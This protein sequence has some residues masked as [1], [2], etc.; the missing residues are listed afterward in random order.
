MTNLESKFVIFPPWTSIFHLPDDRIISL[1]FFILESKGEASSSF[2][3]GL[4]LCMDSIIIPER[5]D[6]KLSDMLSD[7]F[8]SVSV[9]LGKD[10]FVIG[11]VIC[12]ANEDLLTVL[13]VL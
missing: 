6:T 12:C 2:I 1:L 10:G 9:K 5:T 4:P 13:L 7:P 8:D 11:V 3:V